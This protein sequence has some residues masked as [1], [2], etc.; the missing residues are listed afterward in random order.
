M[1]PPEKF[2]PIAEESGLII[3]LG[4][5]IMELAC[6]EAATWQTISPDPVEVAVN[7]SSLQFTRET[8]VEDVTEVLRRTG[9]KPNLLQ[10]ELTESAMLSGVE[11]AAETMKR[12]RA[13]GVS[14]AID[15][16]GTG[17]S[18]LGYLPKLPFGALKIDRSFVKELGSRPE[19]KAMVQS[20]VNLAHNL[21][22]KVIVEGVE[23]PEELA[24]IREFGSNEVQGYLLG[25]PTPDPASHL[26]PFPPTIVNIEAHREEELVANGKIK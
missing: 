1:I 9:L 7:V 8:F 15:D 11:R 18:C 19:T 4:A 16:F 13:L 22:M 17:Y 23:T 21:D 14:L 26:R 20:L 3:P 10:I 25:R 6:T 12:L 5:H 24:M 2:I